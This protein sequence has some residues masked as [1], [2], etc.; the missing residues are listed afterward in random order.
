MTLHRLVLPALAAML[1][2]GCGAGADSKPLSACAQAQCPA[3]AGCDESSG[4]AVCGACPASFV[5]VNGDG[6]LCLMLPKSS[7]EAGEVAIVIN[8]QDPQSVTVGNYYQQA[9][10]IP[11]SNVIVLDFPTAAVLSATDFVAVKQ[12]FD[13]QVGNEIQA[14]ALSFTNPYRVGCMSVTSAFALG[15]DAAYCNT[16]TASCSTT[17]PVDYFNSD[18]N[19]PFDD[20]RVRPAMMLAGAT[21]ADA[22]ALIDRGVSAD[23]TYPLGDGYFVRTS[24]T[25]RSVRYP[26]FVATVA[27]WSYPEGL[28][29]TYLDRSAGGL[30]YITDTTDVLFYFTGLTSVPGISS[31]SYLPGAVADHLTSSGGRVPTSGQMSI[32][33]WLEA[34]VTAS[35]GTVVEPCNYTQK[36]PSPRVML[37]YYFRGASIVEAYWKSVRW[38]GEGLFVGEPLAR[39]WGTRSIVASNG[40]LTLETTILDPSKE[41][42]LSE[43][44]HAAGPFVVVA[45]AIALSQHGLASLKLGPVMGPYL[46]L[47][48][49]AAP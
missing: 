10:G 15:Y 3:D 17:A 2:Q 39:P 12:A 49:V 24:D 23:D 1:L 22:L 38:P 34:G 6:K 36:F 43:A 28:N 25:A 44:E 42:E 45:R 47:A 41:Y 18:S 20:Y 26:D 46:R 27:D 5:D 35:Y 4:V 11:V 33:R 19:R 37:P 13:A 21:T 14:I 8:A 40:T 9:R 32:A 7:I 48:E 29:L 16:T 31:N 30:E